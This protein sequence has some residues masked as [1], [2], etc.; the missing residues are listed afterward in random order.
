MAES[1]HLLMDLERLLIERL[2]FFVSA[3]LEV[4]KRQ[5]IEAASGLRVFGSERFCA[6]L[7]RL[8]KERFGLGVITHA[9]IKRREIVE[10]GGHVGVF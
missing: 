4:E 5:V 8:L 6:D 2:G 10:A 9:L 7:E 3:H 1:E